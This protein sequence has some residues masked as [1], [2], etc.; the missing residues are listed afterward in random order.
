MQARIDAAKNEQY[1]L[2]AELEALNQPDFIDGVARTKF[3][4]AKP[5]DKVLAIIDEP[6]ASLGIGELAVAAAA[7]SNPIDYRNFPV[8]QQWVVFFTTETFSLSIR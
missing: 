7:T 2:E 8:W 6:A 5:G 4:H 3:D 1:E